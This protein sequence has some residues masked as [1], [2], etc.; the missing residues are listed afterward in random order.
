MKRE[1]ESNRMRIPSQTEMFQF[2][3]TT[4]SDYQQFSRG[5]A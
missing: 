5:Q 2:V 1:Q 3:L 4:M